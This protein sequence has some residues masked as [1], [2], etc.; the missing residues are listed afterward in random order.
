MHLT[1]S[2]SD[3]RLVEARRFARIVKGGNECGR[4]QRGIVL[5]LIPGAT[6][7][8]VESEARRDFPSVL[9]EAFHIPI[10][11]LAVDVVANCR[12]GRGCDAHNFFFP[13]GSA[14]PPGLSS[15]WLNLPAT[16]VRATF[17]RL[18]EAR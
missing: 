15:N 6:E 13:R 2:Y 7:P 12:L 10:A 5:R 1:I 16:E 3:G 11:I 4:L 14:V 18:Y 9:E 17:N 8:V